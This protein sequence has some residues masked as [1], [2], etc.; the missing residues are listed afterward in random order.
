MAMVMSAT[1]GAM[2]LVVEGIEMEHAD[3]VAAEMIL[4][5]LGVSASKARKIASLPLPRTAD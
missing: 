2:N 1:M 5:S 3:R 4:R